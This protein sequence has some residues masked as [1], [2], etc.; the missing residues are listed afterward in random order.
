MRQAQLE[1]CPALA[2]QFSGS[3][4][5]QPISGQYKPSL[6][7]IEGSNKAAS[8]Q[9]TAQPGNCCLRKHR[10]LQ[11][12]NIVRGHALLDW[13]L[14]FMVR[15][16]M[17]RAVSCFL[18]P[19]GISFWAAGPMDKF[20]CTPCCR[21][22]PSL[23]CSYQRNTCSVYAGL[24]FDHWFLQLRLGKASNCRCLLLSVKLRVC[25][26]LISQVDCTD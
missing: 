5:P 17:K 12:R 20:T 25:W 11:S 3:P 10:P 1:Q 16:K 22:S 6:S 9:P 4:G 14:F 26:V 7:L 23:L 8:L 2:Q 13:F 18:P 24:Q 19:P 21:H 15:N